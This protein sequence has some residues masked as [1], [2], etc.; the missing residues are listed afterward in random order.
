VTVVVDTSV[1]VDHLR[2][3][4]RA[5]RLVG[6]V[7]RSGTRAAAAV[8]TKIEI[9][10]GVRTDETAATRRLLDRLEWIDVDGEVA[11]RAGDLAARY[12]RS[13]PGIEVVDYVIAATAQRLDAE[14][15]T[16]NIR[17]FPMFPELA[18]PYGP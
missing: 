8:L 4:D 18:A 5:R 17:H 14:L 10:A 12:L 7:A 3:D 11:E 9:L 2:G 16:R 13:H 6:E 15:L 1:L